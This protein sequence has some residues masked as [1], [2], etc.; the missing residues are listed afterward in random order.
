MKNAQKK[1]APAHF[2]QEKWAEKM[3]KNRL[4][5]GKNS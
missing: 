2:C 5:I 1:W 3:G 4:K